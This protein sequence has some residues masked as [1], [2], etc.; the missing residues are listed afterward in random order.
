MWYQGK[1]SYESRHSF[2]KIKSLQE[3]KYSKDEKWVLITWFL[4]F[5]H[6]FICLLIFTN[7]FDLIWT[8]L[9]TLPFDYPLAYFSNVKYFILTFSFSIVKILIKDYGG[10]GKKNNWH[11]HHLF[12]LNKF[13]LELSPDINPWY[14]KF[15]E[16]YITS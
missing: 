3:S 7:N 16:I 12:L 6:S 2:K 1:Q 15:Y 13:I 5:G 14:M 8:H 10:L 9:K 11:C 4:C